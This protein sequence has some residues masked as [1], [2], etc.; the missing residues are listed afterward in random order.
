[1]P[2][3]RRL[4]SEWQVDKVVVDA[5]PQVRQELLLIISLRSER[6]YSQEVDK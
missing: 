5:E 6:A 4:G 1:M 3:A 2:Y